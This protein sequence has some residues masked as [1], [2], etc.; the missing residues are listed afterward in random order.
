[1]YNVPTKNIFLNYTIGTYIPVL[2]AELNR[3]E[4]LQL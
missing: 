2:E 1:M 4:Q 3:V